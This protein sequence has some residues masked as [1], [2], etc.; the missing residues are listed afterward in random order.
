[1]RPGEKINIILKAKKR[2]YATV[3]YIPRGNS[4]EI[5]LMK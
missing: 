4:I 2:I 1:M 3:S 5:E